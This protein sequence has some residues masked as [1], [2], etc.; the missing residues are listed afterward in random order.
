[1]ALL[2]LFFSPLKK[3]SIILT[4][5]QTLDLHTVRLWL[6]SARPSC[7][8]VWHAHT[9]THTLRHEQTRQHIHSHIYK[10]S[11]AVI[12]NTTVQVSL[13]AWLCGY[14]RVQYCQLYFPSSKVNFSFFLTFHFKGI[15]FRHYLDKDAVCKPATYTWHWRSA[16]LQY[17]PELASRFFNGNRIYS[18]S[19]S[20]FYFPVVFPS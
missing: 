19:P 8:S 11:K 2:T 5:K 12:T 13:M 14:C 9:H 1:M 7:L 10:C 17:L 6:L 3:K 16:E 20:H 4:C 18:D 15:S